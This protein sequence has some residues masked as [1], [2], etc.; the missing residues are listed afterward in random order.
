M[1]KFR[2]RALSQP[3]KGLIWELKLFPD[4]PGYS[5]RE[6]DGRVM[7]SSSVPSTILWLRQFSAPYLKRAENPGP[8]DA[9]KFSPASRPRWLL[10]EDGLRMALAFANARYLRSARQRKMF[11]EGLYALPS[12]VI[13]YWFTLCFYGYRQAAGRAALRTLLIHSNSSVAKKKTKKNNEPTSLGSE[14]PEFASPEKAK[15]SAVAEK[16]ARYYAGEKQGRKRE[17]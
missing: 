11:K 6:K 16:L 4:M 14:A 10:W 8:V 13:L 1:E 9:D 17:N 5:R 2:L 7:G 12:E 3:K 15:E